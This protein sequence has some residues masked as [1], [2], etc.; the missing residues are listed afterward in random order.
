VYY[1]TNEIIIAYSNDTQYIY[2]TW[3]SHESS[4]LQLHFNFPC[5]LWSFGYIAISSI[6]TD[7]INVS[8][9]SGQSMTSS[10]R[11]IQRIHSEKVRL[12]VHVPNWKGENPA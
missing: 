6:I 8:I 4:V 2:V 7:M 10:L 5:L 1:K 9:Q 12:F 11:V 3:A